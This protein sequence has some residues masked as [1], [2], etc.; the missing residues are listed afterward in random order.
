MNN[1]PEY[2]GFL[3]TVPSPGGRIRAEGLQLGL[4]KPLAGLRVEAFE[5]RPGSGALWL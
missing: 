2:F 5:S 4:P 3:I 1:G